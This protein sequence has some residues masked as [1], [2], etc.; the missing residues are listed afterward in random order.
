MKTMKTIG[1][2]LYG[3]GN[4]ALSQLDVELLN[5]DIVKQTQSTESDENSLQR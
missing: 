5:K 1:S 2:S 4:V 3:V